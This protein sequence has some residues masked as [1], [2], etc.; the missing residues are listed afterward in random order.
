MNRRQRSLIL[1]VAVAVLVS[2]SPRA[3]AA[4]AGTIVDVTDS[5]VA[6]GVNVDRLQVYEI[7]GIVIIRG[8]TAD[9]AEAEAAGRT[10]RQL[11]YTRIAN[12]VQVLEADDKQIERL[13][14][15]ELSIRRSLDGCRFHV[16]S[17]QGIV[18]LGG[19]VQHEMQKDVAL[20]AIRN[21]DGVRAV[22]S[23]LLRN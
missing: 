17:S 16:A 19:T 6:R 4:S 22:E 18:R 7:G 15:R 21:I 5:F 1:G 14:E 8:R 9:R 3:H 11:G 20:Q 10:A 23:T 13:A 2:L 12:L